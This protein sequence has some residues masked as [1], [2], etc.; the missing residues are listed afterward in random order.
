MFL[1][2]LKF[3]YHSKNQYSVHSPFVYQFLING[4]YKKLD[5]TAHKSLKLGNL[6]SR[7]DKILF[8]IIHYFQPK[9]IL[10]IGKNKA[11]IVMQIA[12]KTAKITTVEGFKNTENSTQDNYDSFQLK[13]FNLQNKTLN[14]FLNNLPE[15]T[16]FDAIYIAYPATLDYFNHLINNIHNDSFIVLNIIYDNYDTQKAWNEIKNHEKVTASIDLF[17]FGLIFFR[18]EQEKQHFILRS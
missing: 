2:Y 18:K 10:E 11:S 5:K 17:Y 9:T 14:D 8:K 12:S 4:L 15:N 16:F 3:L 13:N 6:I 1:S 7:K